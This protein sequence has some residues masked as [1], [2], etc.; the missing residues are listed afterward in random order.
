MLYLTKAKAEL[1]CRTVV[2]PTQHYRSG[3][4]EC[5][6]TLDQF[7]SFQAAG[8]PREISPLADENGTLAHKVLC[9]R[10]DI[11]FM[12]A[13]FH[14]A[15]CYGLKDRVFGDGVAL[16]VPGYLILLDRPLVNL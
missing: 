7:G 10:E 1:H 13:K 3:E 12:R 4:D 5:L 6:I 9:A 15:N 2:P 11:C 14:P 8:S 16:S